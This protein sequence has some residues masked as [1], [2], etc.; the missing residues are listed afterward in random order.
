[1]VKATAL[2]LSLSHRN[3]EQQAGVF[4]GASSSA[5]QSWRVSGAFSSSE[6]IPSLKIISC[7]L[8]QLQQHGSAQG[9]R[10]RTNIALIPAGP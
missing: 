5:Y 2:Q 10:G 1:M 7:L 6:E 8:V 3:M 4:P 9:E